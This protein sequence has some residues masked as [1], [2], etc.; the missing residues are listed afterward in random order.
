MFDYLITHTTVHAWI[1][2]G[3]E[4]EFIKQQLL[5]SKFM[6]LSL[7]YHTRA[8]EYTG[9]QRTQLLTKVLGVV[10]SLDLAC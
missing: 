5:E 7:M 9:C 3:P 6:M 8:G 1:S 4:I 2:S 10:D